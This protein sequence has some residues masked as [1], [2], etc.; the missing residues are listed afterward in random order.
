MAAA[1]ITPCSTCLYDY[2]NWAV[3]GN[4]GW[5]FEEL[6]P[7]FKRSED[8]TVPELWNDPITAKFWSRGGELTLEK[9]KMLG[10]MVPALIK[11]IQ[12]LNMTIV[13][14]FNSGRI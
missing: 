3:S 12:E 2:D 8:F 13:K 14:Y 7:L 11:T 5:S 6:L 9:P 10:R 4:V 1:S